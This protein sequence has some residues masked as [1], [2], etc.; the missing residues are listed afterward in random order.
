MQQSVKW[1]KFVFLSEQIFET[2]GS[3]TLVAAVCGFRSGLRQH[4]DWNF[5]I[6]AEQRNRLPQTHT[7]NA[8][9]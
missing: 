1:L 7:E 4:R 2:K 5:S 8:V 9:M 6:S 3:F